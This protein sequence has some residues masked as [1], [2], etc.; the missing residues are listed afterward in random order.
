MSLSPL[1]NHHSSTISQLFRQLLNQQWPPFVLNKRRATC[2]LETAIISPLNKSHGRLMSLH[3]TTW[4]TFLLWP[5]DIFT[6]TTIFGIPSPLFG[7]IDLL[8][9]SW[10]DWFL[11]SQFQSLCVYVTG[12][13]FN[14]RNVNTEV[15]CVFLKFVFVKL[16]WW[17]RKRV[18]ENCVQYHYI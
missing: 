6:A 18:I 8:P 13:E 7:D 3:G 11:R 2:M 1:F 4:N 15:N 9:V 17:D 10:I 14:F 5:A 16:M 12:G